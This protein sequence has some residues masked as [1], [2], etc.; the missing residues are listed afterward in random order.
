VIKLP[1]NHYGGIHA[2]TSVETF[3][4][5]EYTTKLSGKDAARL[6]ISLIDSLLISVFSAPI[7]DELGKLRLKLSKIRL[8]LEFLWN[9]P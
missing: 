5:S 7:R 8:A 3:C 2:D 4:S 9:Q 6:Y 1:F